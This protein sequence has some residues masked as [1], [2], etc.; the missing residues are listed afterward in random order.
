MA[1]AKMQ[2]VAMLQ[3]IFWRN[4]LKYVGIYIGFRAAAEALNYYGLYL[5]DHDGTLY[6]FGTIAGA[7]LA[8]LPWSRG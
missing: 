7:H 1:N 3:R 8:S 4:I 2:I 5:F 6:L